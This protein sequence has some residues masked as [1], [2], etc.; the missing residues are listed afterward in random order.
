METDSTRFLK[1]IISTIFPT[2]IWLLF[3]VTMGI[4]NAWFF[5]GDYPT[6]GNYIFYGLALATLLLLIRHLYRLWK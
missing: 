3:I 5:F 6:T 2:V 1:K 4:Y